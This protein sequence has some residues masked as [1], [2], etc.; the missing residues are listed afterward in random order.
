MQGLGPFAPARRFPAPVGGLAPDMFT[1]FDE[2]GYL[3]L[4]DFVAPSACDRLRS[5]AMELVAEFDPNEHR[6]VFS[7]AT[8]AHAAETYFQE[9]G[10]K[11]RFFFEEGAFDQHG[12][13]LQEKA[14]SIN[15]IGHA[16]HDL[17]PVFEVFS[18]A[19][20]L[21][22]LAESLPLRRPLLLQSM[23]IFKQP[24]IGGEVAWHVDSTYLHT[25]P[26]SCIGLW[27]A[28]Q[29]AS[30]ENGAM[31]CMPGA[32]RGGL[33][34]RFLRRDGKLVTE[35]LASTP[36][37]DAPIVAL[38]AR[39]GTLVLLHGQL[40]HRSNANFSDLSRHAFTL[41]LIDGACAYSAD[42]WLVRPESF[43]VRGF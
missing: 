10:D 1:A 9:S 2:D 5:R 6:T 29:D 35:Q 22:S 14:L 38:E 7:T 20:A 13:L 28:L 40:P 31:C 33:R 23:Y 18:R 42:N 24:R 11:I 16:M 15:K 32:H 3:V 19:P 30:L 39:K 26:P 43:P 4:E 37:P 21:K 36:W 41:H 34:S 8:R 25:D 12:T 27:F 17:D